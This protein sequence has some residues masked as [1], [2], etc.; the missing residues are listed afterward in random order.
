M[1]NGHSRN[2][3]IG[4]G[5]TIP[6]ALAACA[7]TPGGQASPTP[8]PLKETVTVSVGPCFGFCPVYDVSVTPGGLVQFTGTR[9]TAVLGHQTRDVGPGAYVDFARDLLRFRPATGTDTAVECSA[10]V[11][12]TSVV[13]V[14]WTSTD[15]TK[16]VAKVQSG[17][18][19]GPG[20]AL[21]ELLRDLPLRLGIAGWAKQTTRPGVSRG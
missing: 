16:T 15:G 4:L 10:V 20:K 19:S 12:D 1:I 7:T 18:P 11:S 17:C 21:G 3:M 2:Y 6:F 9:H 5:V 14:T 8:S 13:T